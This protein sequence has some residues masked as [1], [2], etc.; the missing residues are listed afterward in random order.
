MKPKLSFN[1]LLLDAL[2]LRNK[3]LSIEQMLSF[4]PTPQA[5]NYFEISA[6][7]ESSANINFEN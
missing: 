4:F 7:M 2:G 3:P 6:H 5:F 1:P